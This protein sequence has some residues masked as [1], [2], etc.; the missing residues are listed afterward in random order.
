M[1]H[2][3]CARW[4]SYHHPIATSQNPKICPVHSGDASRAG[5]PQAANTYLK[6]PQQ[7]AFGTFSLGNSWVSKTNIQKC[8]L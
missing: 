7:R 5:T 8:S 6:R 3:F 1:I 4:H 2:L